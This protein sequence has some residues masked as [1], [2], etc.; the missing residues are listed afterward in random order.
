MF[1]S[2]GK[3]LGVTRIVSAPIEEAISI[4]INIFILSCVH[5]H[6]ETLRTDVTPEAEA[7]GSLHATLL[8]D[9]NLG[10]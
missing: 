9:E 5:T 6:T 2:D 7:H 3:F 10:A 4:E 8:P 1:P